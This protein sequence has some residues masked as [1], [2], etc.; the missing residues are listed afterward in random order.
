MFALDCTSTQLAIYK[1]P[2]NGYKSHK[3]AFLTANLKAGQK[4]RKLTMITY[5][6]DCDTGALHLYTKS[7]IYSLKPKIGRS[8]IFMSEHLEHSV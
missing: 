7:K 1:A 4:L 5:F 3:D 2:S 8:V 6:S